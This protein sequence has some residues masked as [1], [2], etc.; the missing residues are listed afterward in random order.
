MH[1]LL[2]LCITLVELE[3]YIGSVLTHS[4]CFS[5]SFLSKLNLLLEQVILRSEKLDLQLVS[6]E[7]EIVKEH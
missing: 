4:A 1:K 6:E 5:V 3:T 2:I 7:L